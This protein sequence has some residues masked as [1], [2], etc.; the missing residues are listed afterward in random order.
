MNTY[1]KSDFPHLYP[2]I[3]ADILARKLQLNTVNGWECKA[4][5]ANKH[6]ELK[7]FFERKYCDYDKI[8]KNSYFIGLFKNNKYLFG[9]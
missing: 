5:C 8:L 3:Q 9:L 1:I 7:S 2:K 4:V 6:K